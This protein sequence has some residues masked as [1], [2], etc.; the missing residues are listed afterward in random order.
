MAVRAGIGFRRRRLLGEGR[1][2]RAHSLTKGSVPH[3]SIKNE[4]VERYDA[5][6]YGTSY[7]DNNTY[8]WVKLNVREKR[9]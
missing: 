3:E 6:L 2:L 8:P 1:P 9:E 4:K 7:D 5:V